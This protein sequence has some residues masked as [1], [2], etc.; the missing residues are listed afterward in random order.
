MSK[1]EKKFTTSG[2]FPSLSS[3]DVA[4]GGWGS[5][6]LVVVGDPQRPRVL[7]GRN[8]T[9]VFFKALCLAQLVKKSPNSAPPGGTP[10][11][12]P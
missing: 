2:D 9:D 3:S 7:H 1:V 11:I 12:M 5:K 8:L 6:W 10:D 4:G